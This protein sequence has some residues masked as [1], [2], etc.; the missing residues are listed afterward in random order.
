LSF[1]PTIYN[2]VIN[3]RYDMSGLYNWDAFNVENEQC[4]LLIGWKGISITQSKKLKNS[5]LTSKEQIFRSKK[6]KYT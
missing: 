1:A 5:G 3:I 6:I 2:Y 4:N